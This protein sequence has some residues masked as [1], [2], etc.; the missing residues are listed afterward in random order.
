MSP[1]ELV[2]T[3]F[4]RQG[5][6]RVIALGS[7]VTPTTFRSDHRVG[8]SSSVSSASQQQTSQRQHDEMQA[9]MEAR[10]QAGVARQ[11]EELQAQMQADMQRQIAEMWA[12]M[13]HQPPPPP[14]PRVVSIGF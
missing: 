7:G 5:H 4:G 10:V 6:G 12:T 11:I 3:V 13:G 14:L 1:F 9:E 8:G 2:E